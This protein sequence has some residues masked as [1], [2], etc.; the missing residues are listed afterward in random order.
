MGGIVL[1]KISDMSGKCRLLIQQRDL[2][3]KLTWVNALDCEIAEEREA[4]SYIKRA[5]A[6]DPDLWVVEIEDRSLLKM[7]SAGG[8]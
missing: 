8:L 3:G 2:D 1:Q 6:R 4:D 7:M 5:T